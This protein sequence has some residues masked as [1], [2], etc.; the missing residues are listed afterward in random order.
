MVE[1]YEIDAPPVEDAI[2]KRMLPEPVIWKRTCLMF[3][4]S[5]I[6]SLGEYFETMGR[7][8]NFSV[9]R[10]LQGK[11]IALFIFVRHKLKNYLTDEELA[12]FDE[13]I[14]YCNND[15][16]KDVKVPNDEG[17]G[18]GEPP[19]EFKTIRKQYPL[20]IKRIVTYINLLNAF[21]ERSGIAALEKRHY[22]EDD[23]M[24]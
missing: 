15:G 11:T 12:E 7:E 22:D 9:H 18:I 6:Q 23:V 21:V 8:V 1:I 3:L 20:P 13:L 17:V 24:E 4:E 16:Y 2:K 19:P 14:D 10:L 5:C